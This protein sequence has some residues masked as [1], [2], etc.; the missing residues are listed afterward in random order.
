M[1]RAGRVRHALAKLLSSELSRDG[2]LVR[3]DPEKLWP[4]E[5]YW[6]SDHRADC[7]R[8]EG[9]IEVFDP[10]APEVKYYSAGEVVRQREAG[11]RLVQVASY[12]RMS[13]ILKRGFVY[14]LVGHFL[15]IDLKPASP[16]PP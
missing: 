4:A 13:D 12:E 15:E 9:Q 6:R 16:A 7:Y 10:K 11:W 8:W 2:H 14:S 3:V 5:G 1:R